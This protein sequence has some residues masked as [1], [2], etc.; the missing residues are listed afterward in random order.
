[1]TEAAPMDTHAGPSETTYLTHQETRLIV[2]GVLLPL[3]MGSL[4]NTILAS[5]LPTIGRA[6]GDVHGLPWLIT[7]YLL[8]ATA[9]MPLYGKIADIH[10]RRFALYIAIALH[11]AGSLVCALAPSMFVLILGRA[12]QGLGGSGLSAVSVIVL[13][14]A[15][16]PKD[17]GRYYA[18]FS[19][20]YTTAGACGPALGGLIADHLHWSAIFWL[21]LPLGLIAFLITSTVLRRLPR[22]ERPHRLDVIGAILIVLASVSFMLALNLGGKTYAWLSPTVL[23]LFAGALVVGA[24]FLWR[25]LTAPEPLIPLAILTDPIVRWAVIANSFGWASI[26]GLNIFL[27]I[28]LQSVIGLSPTSAGLSL[29]VLMV[30]LNSS[31]GLAGQV[32]GRVTHYKLLPMCMLV[33]ALGAVTLLALWA[34]RMTLLSFEV[35]LFLIGAGFGPLP[36]LC[37]VAIQN[38]VARHQLGIA[39]GT[40]SFMRNLFTTMLVALLGV[41]VLAVTSSLEPGGA[42]EFGG[43]LSPAAA[44]AAEAFR[45]VFFVV[46]ACLAIAFVA[47]VLVEEKPL[48]TGL[49]EEGK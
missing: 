10:G 39:V 2:F 22:N 31:A 44:E 18:Y 48:K 13:G 32:L 21:N 20:V 12:L 45:R 28:Y 26:I 15:A 1:V 3:F 42:G 34:D 6:F 17:R 47:I 19:I 35:L 36:S 16:A 8:A 9:A 46:A 14:D 29:M 38:A 49:V 41:I 11:M 24:G 43:A 33:I 5:A 27:P 30:S 7:I 37:T 25:L 23:L 4:D 40:M